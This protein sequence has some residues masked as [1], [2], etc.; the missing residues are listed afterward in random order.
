ML[1]C[2]KS[3]DKAGKPLSMRDTLNRFL[4][5]EWGR[6]GE[7]KNLCSCTHSRKAKDMERFPTISMGK[8]SLV[9]SI[10]FVHL[11]SGYNEQHLFPLHF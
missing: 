5:K 11:F 9:L 1:T 2:R 3:H 7:R 8:E 4:A 10:F 6:G